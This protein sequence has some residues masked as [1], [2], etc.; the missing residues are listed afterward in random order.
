[1]NFTLFNEELHLLP[2]KAI[3]WPREKALLIA[4]AHFGKVGHFR[5][6]GVPIP[7]QI[8]HN[9]FEILTELL[10]TFDIKK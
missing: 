10:K 7:N 5:K 4:D 3:Y 8:T 6:A 1:M 2:Q 9:D